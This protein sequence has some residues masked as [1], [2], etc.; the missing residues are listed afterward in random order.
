MNRYFILFLLVLAGCRKNG[1]SPG[2]TNVSVYVTGVDDGAVVYWKDEQEFPLVYAQRNYSAGSTGIAVSNGDVYVSGGVG[3]T[4]VY[5]KNGVATRLPDPDPGSITA[6]GV[7]VSGTDIYF[8]GVGTGSAGNKVV[9][10]KNGVETV[11]ATGSNTFSRVGIAVSGKDVYIAATLAGD[12]AV[13]WKNGV[14]V[15]LGA[16][17]STESGI[18]LAGGNVFVIG[19]DNGLPVFW[20]NGAETAIDHLGS[21][22]VSGIAVSGSDVYFAGT[23]GLNAVSWKNGAENVIG[24]GYGDGIAVAGSDVYVTGVSEDLTIYASPV[25]ALYWKNGTL[26]KFAVAPSYNLPPQGVAIVVASR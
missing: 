7:A 6:T 20:K 17:N 9:Y 5:W 18:A 4:A 21:T 11:V 25:Y 26:V 15:T 16:P 14:R 22:E 13:Y 3:D 12:T 10:W 23:D 2:N 1:G 24:A 19:Q 8:A